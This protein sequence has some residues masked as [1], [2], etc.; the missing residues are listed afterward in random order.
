MQPSTPLWDKIV[1]ATAHALDCG[2]L[3]SI[4]TGC[5]LVEDGGLRFVVRVSDNLWRKDQQR[6]GSTKRDSRE[7]SNP[8]LPYEPDLFVTDISDTHVGLLNRFNVVQHH[9]LMVTRQFEDQDLL[10]SIADL[11]ALWICLQQLDGLGFYN[12][13]R[14]AGA[15]QPHRHLQL[16]PLP[17]AP[18]AARLPVEPALAGA[19]DGGSPARSAQLPFAHALWGLDDLQSSTPRQAA[20]LL[21]R[22][23]LALLAEVGLDVAD[24]HGPAPGPYNLLATRRWM[25]LVPRSAEHFQGISFNALAFAGSFFVRHEGELRALEQAGPLNT[26]CAVAGRRGQNRR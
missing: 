5:R 11:E 19:L 2:A 22:R 26:L 6:A 24:P 18:G 13:G 14:V 4:A 12:G 16:V 9:L 21:R 15:S 20:P 3:Q 17:F 10:L 23:Y 1:A 8:F 25:M 7:T